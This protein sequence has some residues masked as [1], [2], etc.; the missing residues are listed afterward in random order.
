MG[1]GVR[2]RR[3]APAAASKFEFHLKGQR[4]YLQLLLQMI[5]NSNKVCIKRHGFI[6]YIQ[7]CNV[8]PS[9]QETN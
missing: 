6:L 4:D 1:V 9:C 5:K 2:G 7:S 3:H 8:V